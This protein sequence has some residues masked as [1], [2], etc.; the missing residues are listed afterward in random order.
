MGSDFEKKNRNQISQT[1]KNKER[2]LTKNKRQGE[3]RMK[4]GKTKEEENCKNH[5]NDVIIL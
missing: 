4:R 1:P 3:K 5:A 2:V